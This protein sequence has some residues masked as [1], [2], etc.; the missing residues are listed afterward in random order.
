MAF[1]EAADG[2]AA[3]ALIALHLCIDG[4]TVHRDG[5]GEGYYNLLVVIAEDGRAECPVGT[6]VVLAEGDALLRLVLRATQVG[7][8]Q[9]R[10]CARAVGLHHG[11]GDGDDSRV[12]TAFPVAMR[13]P[14]LRDTAS[15]GKV[16]LDRRGASW[17]IDVLR[18][19][20]LE[21]NGEGDV[22]AHGGLHDEVHATIVVLTQ[23]CGKLP[24]ATA[25]PV[26]EVKRGSL[27]VVEAPF[28]KC[29]GL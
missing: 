18:L 11:T 25:A 27:R 26:A 17:H 13:E 12:G 29:Y 28:A 8:G 2:G 15:K 23:W 10:H 6:P 4:Q 16:G 14:N 22:V 3:P 9:L 20:T 5:L 19:A 1:G 7:K 21:G 24:A